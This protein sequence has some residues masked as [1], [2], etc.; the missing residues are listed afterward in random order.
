MEKFVK[1]ELSSPARREKIRLL[2]NRQCLCM[3]MILIWSIGLLDCWLLTR[4]L[5]AV[6]V[7][8]DTDL[9]QFIN[10][11][12]KLFGNLKE[13]ERSRVHFAVAEYYYKVKDFSDAKM[14]FEDY[15][16]R[17]KVGMATL[18]ANAYLYKLAKASGYEDKAQTIKKE[19]FRDQFILLFNEYK[20]L[21]YASAGNNKYEIHYF[22][23]KIEIFLNGEIFEQISP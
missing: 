3:A 1:P 4:R 8:I 6:E 5:G 17:N 2:P 14:A 9:N 18:L 13:T 21:H 22:I 15:I 10:L 16:A 12:K 20:T 7:A 19:M 23:D 11:R